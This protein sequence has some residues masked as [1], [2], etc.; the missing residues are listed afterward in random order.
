VLLDSIARSSRN[1]FPVEII[2]RF[3]FIGFK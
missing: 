1:L 2:L 3:K